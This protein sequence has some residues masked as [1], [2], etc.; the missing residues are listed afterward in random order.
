MGSMGGRRHLKREAAP[1]FWPIHRKRF[2]W[3]IKPAPGPHP[4][5]R[6]IPLGVIVRDQLGYAKTGKEAKKIISQ[7]KILVDGRVRRDEHFP[8]GPMDVITIPEINANYRVLPWKEG[9]ILHQISEDEAKYKICRIENKTT[10]TG[11]HIQLNLHDGRNILIRSEDP[12]NPAGSVF[13]TLDSLKI[14]IPDQRIIEHLS[15]D[16][17]KIAMIIGG[18]NAGKYGAIKAIENQKGQKKRNSLVTI[19]DDGG[20][21][22]R[23]ILAYTFVIGEKTPIISLPRLEGAQAVS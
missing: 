8:V 1:N 4:I 12:H 3:I 18:K 10:L 2:T 23:T 5:S 7:G 6:C 13:Q 16:L 14:E 9:L 17:G 21:E 15:L 19:E 11:G 22:L 20:E